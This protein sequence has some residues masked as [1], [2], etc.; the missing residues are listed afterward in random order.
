MCIMMEN[1]SWNYQ[2]ILRNEQKFTLSWQIFMNKTE[3]KNSFKPKLFTFLYLYMELVWRYV[4]IILF[5]PNWNWLIFLQFVVVSLES[6]FWINLLDHVSGFNLCF[7]LSF[8]SWSLAISTLPLTSVLIFC[9]T[10]NMSD[11]EELSKF[12]GSY[13]V[14]RRC[15]EPLGTEIQALLRRFDIQNDEPRN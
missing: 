15:M 1:R 7:D 10:S 5:Y 11:K 4:V 2:L 14:Y 6:L 8:L 13:K 3:R 12:R 9:L